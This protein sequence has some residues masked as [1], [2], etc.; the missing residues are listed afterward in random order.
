MK[1]YSENYWKCWSNFLRDLHLVLR[2]YIVM[3]GLVDRRI[4]SYISHVEMP[5]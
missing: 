5:K 2:I 4:S 1:N 3:P